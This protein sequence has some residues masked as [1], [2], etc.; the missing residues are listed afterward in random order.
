MIEGIYEQL[1]TKLIASK[2][3]EIETS[4]YYIKE[5]SIDKEEDAQ[6]LSKH[7]NIAIG[8]ALSLIKGEHAIETQI[9]IANKIIQILRDELNNDQIDGD[10][11]K[12]EGRILKAVFEKTDAHFSDLD[13]HLKE[14]TPYTRLTHSELFTGGNVGLSLESELKKE[15]LSSNR[16]D[17][18][19]S[20]IKWKGIVI[21][22]R[23]LREFTERGGQLR[24]ITTTYMGASDY[25]AIQLLSKL[26][27]TEVKISYNIG[28]ERL[29]AKAYFFY[30][31]TGFHTGYIGSSN[32]S[33]TA[34]TD[35]LEWNLKI[36]TKEVSHIIN[37]FQKTFEVYWQNNEFELFDD[38]IHSKKLIT[39]LK[40][41]K[42]PQQRYNNLAFFDLKPYP[43]QKEILET[44]EVE[45]SVHNRYKNL[46]VAATGTG[47]T[48]ISAFD[49]KRFK[50]K[51]K[52]A[53]LLFVAHRK[54]ILTQAIS[55]FQGVLK[56]NN[57]GELW[58]DGMQPDKFNFVFASVQTLRNRIE[59]LSLSPEFY[60]FIIID[61]V[62]HIS[63]SSYRPTLNHFNP[64][65]LLGL[66][67]TP[68]RM[69]N[70]NI[71]DDFCNRIAAEIRLPE[72]LNKKLLCPFQYFGISDSIDLSKVRWENGRYVP[73]ELT[74][75]YMANDRRVG[76]VIQN[77][78]KYLRDIND[79]RALG[80]CVTIEHAKFMAE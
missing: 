15:I 14:I 23:E 11:I 29:H 65:I 45:R 39:S 28:N 75:L 12:T 31:N 79:V 71:L 44:L 19:V 47:K 8:Y 17:L 1:I 77:A 4:Q 38:K 72:A 33:R 68:E 20:F 2:L 61:E 62:H 27:N 16:V 21:L 49:Y 34:L 5:S 13:L 3:E 69:D 10:L 50:E 64:K 18:L 26:P 70:E 48:V 51:N 56:D 41:G 32:F 80:F 60:D 78:D 57:F 24:V 46:L 54:E 35:G 6:I 73:S 43:Y 7:L 53:K 67:A 74:K 22:E 30:R 9:K 42:M 36:T 55:T 40:S 25:K 37:K 58:V 66:T 59:E 52:T 76:E 63:A